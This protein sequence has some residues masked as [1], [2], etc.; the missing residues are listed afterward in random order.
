L[1]SALIRSGRF[2]AILPALPPAAGDAK[3]RLEI[4]KALT[5]KQGF[6]FAPEL[7][8]TLESHEEGI[9][10]MLHDQRIWTGAEMEVVLKEAIDNACFDNRG[11]VGLADW[12]QAFHDVLPST[13]E[14]EKM[15]DLSLLFVNHLGYCPEDWRERAQKKG[16]IMS[17]IKSGYE[18]GTISDRDV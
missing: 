8:K 6:K 5:K 15:I 13:R 12:N 9:G 10:K 3:G 4:L 1:D 18:D 11:A 17:S 7:S 2:D 14:V 16:E